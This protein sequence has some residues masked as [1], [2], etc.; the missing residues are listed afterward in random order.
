MALLAGESLLDHAPATVAE[1]IER[2]QFLGSRTALKTFLDWHTTKI[3]DIQETIN[4]RQLRQ[5]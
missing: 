4:N 5:S 3:K 2:E 1:L